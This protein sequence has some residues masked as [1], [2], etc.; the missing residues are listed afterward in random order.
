MPLH[1]ISSHLP[2]YDNFS[3]T[4]FS[5]PKQNRRWSIRQ[6]FR[7]EPRLHWVLSFPKFD[8]IIHQNMCHHDFHNNDGKK[9]AWTVEETKMIIKP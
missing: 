1:T 8:I 5:L 2:I 7:H 3:Q 6:V 9:P 4:F